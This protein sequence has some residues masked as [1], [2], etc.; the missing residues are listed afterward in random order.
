VE[1]GGRAVVAGARLCAPGPI[2]GKF[3]QLGGESGIDAYVQR[4]LGPILEPRCKAC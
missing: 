1:R 4:S 2:A 3:E